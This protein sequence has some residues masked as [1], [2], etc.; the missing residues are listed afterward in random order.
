MLKGPVVVQ[1][2]SGPLR[3][4]FLWKCIPNLLVALLLLSPVV[5]CRPQENTTIETS[6]ERLAE[7]QKNWGSKMNSPGA[8]ITLKE[9][10]RERMQQGTVVHYHLSASGMAG[11]QVYTLFTTSLGLS[12]TPALEGIT[13][14]RSGVAVCA[15]TPGTCTGEKPNDPIDLAVLA[16][17][18]EPKRFAVLSEDKESKAFAYVVP[19]PILGKDRGCTAEAIL[20]TAKAEAVLIRAAGF[21]PGTEVRFVGL[22]DHETQQDVSKAGDDGSFYHVALPFVKGKS[23][24][25]ARITLQSSACSPSL[26]FEW[27]EGTAYD[28]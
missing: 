24:G 28:Q 15:G 3:T 22:S 17:K 7:V 18:G 10:G 20:L 9:I 26:L 23:H 14:D 19:F 25:K 2:A 12:S 27:G 21:V 13:F 8:A 4:L 5:F 11:D 16:A 6:V 1:A